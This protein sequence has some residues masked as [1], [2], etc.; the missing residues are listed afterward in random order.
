MTELKITTGAVIEEP[1]S[2]VINKT[3]SW[4]SGKKPVRNKEK[5]IKCMRCWLVCPDN[6]IGEDIKTNYDFCKGCGIC[7]AECPVK[8]IDMI[9]ADIGSKCEIQPKK[10][11]K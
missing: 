5:C 6:A 3:G 1:G 10:S 8:C 11:K 7:A 9:D 4:R 2:S